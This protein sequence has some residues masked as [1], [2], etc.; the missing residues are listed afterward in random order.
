VASNWDGVRYGIGGCDLRG[1][2]TCTTGDFSATM[3]QVG[4]AK[5]QLASLQSLLHMNP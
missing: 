4:A 2:E 3:A 5:R 1:V